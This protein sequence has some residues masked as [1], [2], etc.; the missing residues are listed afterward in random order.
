MINI[1]NM[2]EHFNIKDDEKLLLTGCILEAGFKV[3]ISAPDRITNEQIAVYFY[4][5]MPFR[6]LF[7]MNKLVGN[8]VVSVESCL[9]YQIDICFNRLKNGSI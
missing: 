2:L 7:G 6:Y 8:T 1:K 4:E 3:D 5:H 9:N